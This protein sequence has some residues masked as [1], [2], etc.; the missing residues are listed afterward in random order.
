MGDLIKTLDTELFQHLKNT[1]RVNK[2]ADLMRMMYRW[3]FYNYKDL[4]IQLDRLTLK[5]F[6]NDGYMSDTNQD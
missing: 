5:N 1:H 3:G 2:V 6:Q 4:D